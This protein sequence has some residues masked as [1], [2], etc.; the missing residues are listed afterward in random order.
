M[1]MHPSSTANVSI[2]EALSRTGRFGASLLTV[3]LCL[4]TAP[5][6]AEFNPPRVTQ[7][8][9]SASKRASLHNLAPPQYCVI[10]RGTEIK[11]EKGDLLNIYRQKRI[12]TRPLAPI[13]VFLGSLVI[14]SSYHGSSMGIFTPDP[15]AIQ[16]PMLRH[17]NI[18]QGD[19]AI[20][21]LVLDSDVLFD[22]SQANLK[23]SAQTEVA[24]VADFILYHQPPTL[25]IE[26]HTDSDGDEVPNQVLSERR[27]NA[28]RQML[29][30]NHPT[31]SPETI[32]ARGRGEERPI[33]PNDSPA[34]KT[35]NRRLEVIVIWEVLEERAKSRGLNDEEEDEADLF[36]SR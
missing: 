34:N 18:M 2:R 20:P 32:Q 10:N 19:V 29:L 30:D 27:A 35:M 14:T 31:I 25:I 17:R 7:V 8:I 11:I 24:K 33:A 1:V 21:S 23:A 9:R 4:L 3:V 12:I 22:P 6:L 13:Q 16:N 28:L 5:L 26:G 36:S 15:D